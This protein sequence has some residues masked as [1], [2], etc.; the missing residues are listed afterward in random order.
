MRELI[1]Q[2]AGLAR[3]AA[4]QLHQARRRSEGGRDLR[5]VH[6]E[7]LRFG[8][9]DVILGQMRDGLE[10]RRTQR[11]VKEAR[12]ERFGAGCE[13]GTDGRFEIDR[14]RVPHQ[15]TKAVHRPPIIS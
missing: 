13:T 12:L 11:V 10:K 1:E 15:Q 4:A 6:P 7:D 5:G 9:C 2:K 8:A 3:A 14:V